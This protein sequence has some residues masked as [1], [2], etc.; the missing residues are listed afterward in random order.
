MDDTA[1]MSD[2]RFFVLRS[3]PAVWFR[4][5]NEKPREEG[6]INEIAFKHTPADTLETMERYA[7]GKAELLAG[8]DT[9]L[10]IA[11][12]LANAWIEHVNTTLRKSADEQPSDPV[13]GGL[14]VSGGAAVGISLLVLA[15][16]PVVFI[17]WRRRRR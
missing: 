10:T 1:G 16:I 14:G 2:H 5:M 11:Y 4:G 17:I 8:I 9:G 3:I 12:D 13:E 15:M 7:G 6:D